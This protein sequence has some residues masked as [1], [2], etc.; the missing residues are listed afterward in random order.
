MIVALA[1]SL[2]SMALGKRLVADQT[3]AFSLKKYL[4]A[5]RRV[6]VSFS[7]RHVATQLLLTFS[8]KQRLCNHRVGISS[9]KRPL[10][11]HIVFGSSVKRALCIHRVGISWVK[12]PLDIHLER[13]CSAKHPLATH[14]ERVCSGKRSL[15]CADYQ[16]IK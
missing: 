10:C 11:I 15:C 9:T 14:R 5:M 2:P 12:H 8:T 4:F 3:A 1:Y 7:N 16:P 13:I 6:D